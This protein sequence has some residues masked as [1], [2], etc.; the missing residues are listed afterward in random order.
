[1]EWMLMPYRRYADFSGR[2][3]R[4]EFWMFQL[5]VFLVV[6]VL[7]IV[8]GV[9]IAVGGDSGG[10]VLGGMFMLLFAVFALGSLIPSLAVTVRRLHDTDKS[11][12]MILLGLIPLVGSIILLVFYCTEGTRGPNRFGPDPKDVSGAAAFQ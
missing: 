11:G 7:Q 8:G 12:W 3:R 9:G 10:G 4:Q 1:M 5:L 6:V 2:S